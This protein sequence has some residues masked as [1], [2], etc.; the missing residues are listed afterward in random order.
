[1]ITCLISIGAV[2]LTVIAICV[3]SNY[4]YW[5]GKLSGWNSCEKMVQDRADKSHNFD[6]NLVWTELLQ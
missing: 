2:L 3:F 1:M 6:K 4:Y 5:K